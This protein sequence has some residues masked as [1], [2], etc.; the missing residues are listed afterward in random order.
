[1]KI[2]HLAPGK[3]KVFLSSGDLFG[4]N[5]DPSALSPKSPQLAALL[6]GVVGVIGRETDFAA[7]GAQIFAAARIFGEGVEFLLSRT[8]KTRINHSGV[9][10]TTFE[11]SNAEDLFFA[12]SSVGNADLLM[13]RLYSYRGRFYLSVPEQK[14]PTALCEFSLKIG[15]RAT[16]DSML[17]EHGT[18]L[19]DGYRLISMAAC[20]KKLK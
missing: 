7:D 19:A 3:I 10:R 18:L 6:A 15:S 14:V 8:K 11:F 13:M 4:M 17:R 5:I 9:R 2:T 20:L 16:G 1:M 12:L